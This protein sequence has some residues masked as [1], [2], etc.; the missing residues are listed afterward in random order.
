MKR[1]LI[2]VATLGMAIQLVSVSAQAQRVGPPIVGVLTETED[3]IWLEMFSCILRRQETISGAEERA[4][5]STN[6]EFLRVRAA[7]PQPGVLTET[8]GRVWLEMFSC[9]LRRQETIS[10]AEERAV[11]STNSEFVRI[12]AALPQVNQ[13]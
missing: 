7:L 13:R 11:N 6:S 1:L 2:C 4:V 10:G 8:E 12:R 3:R 5:D 9:I